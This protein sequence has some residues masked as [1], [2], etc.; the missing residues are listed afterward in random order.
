MSDERLDRLVVMLGFTPGGRQRIKLPNAKAINAAVAYLNAAVAYLAAQK[1]QTDL[2]DMEWTTDDDWT[3]PLTHRLA[4]K[5]KLTAMLSSGPGFAEATACALR[6]RNRGGKITRKKLANEQGVS[7]AT[8][9]RR[10]SPREFIAIKRAATIPE[11]APKAEG[12]GAAVEFL[13]QKLFEMLNSPEAASMGFDDSPQALAAFCNLRWCE[14]SSRYSR[15]QIE[16]AYRE[17]ERLEI[18]S[19]GAS[20]NPEPR[21]DMGLG[22][23]AV[24]ADDER[25]HN[26]LAQLVSGSN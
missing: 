19:W 17:I 15:A 24:K 6:I 5:P 10:F 23:D 21:D 12:R 3:T 1:G 8:H 7:I 25:F 16:A 22:F 20:N 9:R 13:A 2:D 14:F 11:A 26:D 18:E 4:S